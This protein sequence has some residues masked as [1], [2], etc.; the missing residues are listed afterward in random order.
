MHSRIY[1]LELF[2]IWKVHK[3][4]HLLCVEAEGYRYVKD[5]ITRGIAVYYFS[6]PKT[7]DG[8]KLAFGFMTRHPDGTLVRID[9]ETSE[10]FIE[11]KL[12]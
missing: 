1:A 7:T 11:A 9:S 5:G 2:S 12:V 8:D 6:P 3:T 4:W 10:D